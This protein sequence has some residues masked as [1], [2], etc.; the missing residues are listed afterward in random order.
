MPR[1]SIDS[2][3]YSGDDGSENSDTQYLNSAAEVGRRIDEACQIIGTRTKAA[4]VAHLSTDQLLRII[5]GE[6]VPN[7]FSIQAIAK[8]AGVSMTWIAEGTGT[9][10]AAGE[11]SHHSWTSAL[12]QS[13]PVI[14][15]AECG[16]RGW[17]SEG[18]MAVRAA[19]P[20]DLRNPEA[21]A[22]M[23][24]GMSMVPAGIQPGFLCFCDPAD[25][26]DRGDAVFVGR[27]DGRGSIKIFGGSEPGWVTLQGWLDPDE[28]GRQQS[29][30]DKQAASQIKRLATVVYV[31]RKL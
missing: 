30:L 28:T 3:I 18:A 21:F 7:F 26:P 16:L 29:Y 2:M 24:I 11:S 15:L 27:A 12:P 13:V 14:G 5:R 31:K 19:R 25:S 23:A 10:L 1:K 8:A 4:K 17:F 20:G 6:S 22:V 9:M